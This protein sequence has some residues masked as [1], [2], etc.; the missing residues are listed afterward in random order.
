MLYKG[1]LT[2]DSLKDLKITHCVIAGALI[3]A[4]T[5]DPGPGH[6]DKHL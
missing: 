2:N 5:T 4:K 3:M 6:D 1:S